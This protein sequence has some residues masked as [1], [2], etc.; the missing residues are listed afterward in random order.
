MADVVVVGDEPVVDVVDW[1]VL[2]PDTAPLARGVCA[3]TALM[4]VMVNDDT[5]GAANAVVTANFLRN[6]R[7]PSSTPSRACSNSWLTSVPPARP[8]AAAPESQ[9]SN[10]SRAAAHRPSPR[11]HRP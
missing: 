7:R 4:P 5:T 6:A 10:G 8:G 11:G 9:Q 3:Y 1:L 2:P